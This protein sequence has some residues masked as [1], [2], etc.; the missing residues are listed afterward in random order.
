MGINGKQFYD[1]DELLEAIWSNPQRVTGLNFT[2]RGGVWQSRQRLD[3]SETGRQD[4]TIL[5]RASNGQIFV[6]YNGGSYPAGQDIW[7]FLQWK[8]N[9]NE[10]L[11]VLHIVGDAYGIAPDL[12]NYT[13]EQ[14]QRAE[15]RRSE[16]Q[17]LKDIAGW[18]TAA[19]GADIGSATR[20]YLDARG[21]KPTERM[22]AWN[23]AIKT[24]IRKRM[25]EKYGMTTTAADGYLVRY[26]TKWSADD[27]QLAIPFYNGSSN[28]VGFCLRRTT[29]AIT[30][31][32]KDG[33]TAT[34]PKYLYSA[35]MPRGGG[36]CETLH[37]GE[38]S[39]LLVEGILDAEAM[40][41]YG[42][43]NVVA[44]GGMTPTDNDDD[45]AKSMVKTLQRYNAKKLI[46][47]P[48]CEYNEDGTRKTDATLR[49]ISALL[50]Y[51]TGRQH[52]D[53]FVSVRVADL[54]T[55]DSRQHHT[56]EDADTF[57]RKCGKPAMLY[58][59]NNA[60]AW[61]EYELKDIA[62]R[63]DADDDGMATAA[64]EVFCNME[65]AAQRQQMTAIWRGSNVPA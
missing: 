40:K 32:D 43:A 38:E 45:A 7:Q 31:T 19:L 1:M 23:N 65:N 11:D 46:Y 22:G 39:V 6:N 16:K 8:N 4:K 2:R 12:S 13:P 15:Q 30:Y 60:T 54:E 61:Y 64:V 28:V 29:D 56:K 3:G 21:L 25:T 57:L 53:G 14:Q 58:A 17:L 51:V 47:I 41:Q 35:E 20:D 44:C 42:F 10:F 52:G 49:T 59:V 36:Y 18:I 27:Y 9:T 34:K 48:D 33:N 37:G 62:R 63:Y 50:P 5:R 55:A 24:A 26:F